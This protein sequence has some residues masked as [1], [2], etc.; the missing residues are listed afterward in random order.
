MK[1]YF[2]TGAATALLLFALNASAFR[3][4][5]SFS[6]LDLD[7]DGTVSEVEFAAPALEHASERF[8]EADGDGDGFVT[9][10]EF[11]VPVL[12]HVADRFTEIDEDGDGVLSEAELEARRPRG[13]RRPGSVG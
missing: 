9:E 13:H 12:E 4:H 7:G 1:T 11:T 5:V 6:E 2:A 3:P 8:T 10:E